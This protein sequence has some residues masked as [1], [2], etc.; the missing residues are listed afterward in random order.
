MDILVNFP[1]DML[2][3]YQKLNEQYVLSAPVRTEEAK[4]IRKIMGLG[5]RFLHGCGLKWNDVIEEEVPG[6]SG[7]LP[8]APANGDRSRSPSPPIDPL[9]FT[10]GN[11]LEITSLPFDSIDFSPD[12]TFTSNRAYHAAASSSFIRSCLSYTKSGGCAACW[13]VVRLQAP[14]ELRGIDNKT[15]FFSKNAGFFSKLFLCFKVSG[16]WFGV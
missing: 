3:T 8:A 7:G 9:K 5:V 1:P 6:A 11:V 4:Q 16:F 10:D 2:A 12:I 13:M 14:H 15:G